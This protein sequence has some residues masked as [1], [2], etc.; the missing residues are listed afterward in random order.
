MRLHSMLAPPAVERRVHGSI[1]GEGGAR[2]RDRLSL[3]DLDDDESS[4]LIVYAPEWLLHEIVDW[5][6]GSA[7]S[8][9]AVAESGLS[10]VLSKV[11]CVTL[12][13][14]FLCCL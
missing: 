13:K 14:A 3:P 8:V 6:S 4:Y 10:S 9:R 2:Q 7:I 12:R 5:Y 11:C 1:C